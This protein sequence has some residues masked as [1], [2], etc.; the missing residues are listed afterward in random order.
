MPRP[1][2]TL[3]PG[4]RFVLP[5]LQ[6]KGTLISLGPSS[7]YVAYDVHRMTKFKTG[8]GKRVSF[9]KAEKVNISLGT[10]V[11]RLVKKKRRRRTMR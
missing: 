11:I 2:H 4:Q 7:A 5:A 6:K 9:Q 1:I 10:M 8:D 3:E